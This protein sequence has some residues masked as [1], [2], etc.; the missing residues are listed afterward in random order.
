M[1]LRTRAMAAASVMSRSASI[2]SDSTS[3]PR[4]TFWVIPTLSCRQF[5]GFTKSSGC[6]SVTGFPSK[7]ASVSGRNTS[8][9]LRSMV[10]KPPA[11]PSTGT[12][13]SS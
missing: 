1:S 2:R 8:S 6:E 3:V 12:S 7:L 10:T 4:R 5:E 11:P 13:L 9:A